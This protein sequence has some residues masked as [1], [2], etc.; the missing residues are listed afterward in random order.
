[1]GNASFKDLKCRWKILSVKLMYHVL[2]FL[3]LGKSSKIVGRCVVSGEVCHQII[4]SI[5][6][7]GN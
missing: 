1:M 7:F 4:Y 6:A 2:G 5:V 3:E